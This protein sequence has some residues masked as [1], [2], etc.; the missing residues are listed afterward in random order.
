MRNNSFLFIRQ[1][2]LLP[3]TY[4][5]RKEESRY[6]ISVCVVFEGNGAWSQ[7]E[8]PP[9]SRRS[10]R[11]CPRCW[12]QTAWDGR[13]LMAHHCDQQKSLIQDVRV[14]TAKWFLWCITPLWSVE[15]HETYRFKTYESKCSCSGKVVPPRQA[16]DWKQHI[17]A[18]T[19][20]EHSDTGLRAIVLALPKMSCISAT[21]SW[22]CTCH[23]VTNENDVCTAT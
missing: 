9:H 2:I 1:T 12:K 14:E 17:C 13:S 21:S 4:T 11:Q 10:W 3:L 6:H 22:G 5:G 16:S 15:E 8:H 19:R 23:R 18:A 20:L 7:V